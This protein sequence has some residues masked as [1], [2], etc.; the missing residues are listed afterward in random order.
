MPENVGVPRLKGAHCLVLRPEGQARELVA[1][2]GA[3]GAAVTHCPTIAIDVL[4][5]TPGDLAGLERVDWL[6][7]I[8]PNAVSMG[9]EAIRAAGGSLPRRA[10]IVAVGAGTAAALRE[11]GVTVDVVPTAGGGSD[12]LLREPRL[13][14]LDGARVL[15]VRGEGGR[16]HLARALGGRGATVDYLE[17]YRRRL[18]EVTRAEGLLHGWRSS[19]ARVTIVTSVTGWR[20]LLTLTE[21]DTRT[22]VLTG[23]LVAVSDRVLEATRG[24]GHRGPAAVA[25][26]PGPPALVEAAAE[27]FRKI[28]ETS[29]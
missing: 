5:V 6:V 25:V 1:R 18:P 4:P 15:I 12:A 10:G 21:G 22:A 7:F 9:L 26:E 29:T 8:S 17:V 20:N 16:E 11:A 23:A 28:T 14:A 27:A 3:E 24:D 2:L 19:A 13:A